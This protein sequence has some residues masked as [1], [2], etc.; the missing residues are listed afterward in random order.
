MSTQTGTP[1]TPST[2]ETSAD[3]GSLTERVKAMQSVW[4][5]GSC[6]SSSPSSASCPRAPSS[7]PAT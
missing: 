2:I 5:L 6:S 1:T 4:I 3:H 7:R